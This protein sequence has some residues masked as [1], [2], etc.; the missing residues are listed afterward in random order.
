MCL[1]V[2]CMRV[3]ASVAQ[4]HR[5][6]AVAVADAREW[7]ATVFSLGDATH[8][9]ARWVRRPGGKRQGCCDGLSW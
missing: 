3:V 6:R 5:D 7:R 2:T 8:S 1:L 4:Q 9:S